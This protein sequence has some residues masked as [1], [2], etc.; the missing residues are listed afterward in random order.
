MA[1]MSIGEVARRSG[2]R[3]SAIRYYEKLG[4]LPPPSRVSG[5]R[6]YDANVLDRLA[7]VSFAKYV[8]FSIGEIRQLLNGFADRPPPERWR[9]MATRK[10]AE[11]DRV[12]AHARG[13]RSELAETL[14][15]KCPKLVECGRARR[16]GETRAGLSGLR[17]RQPLR[18]DH[19][20]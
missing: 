14:K 9:N 13:V 5:Q 12:I 8:G 2:M 19:R 10:L 3:S 6:R 18:R 1:R 7:I 4:L 20:A 15:R 16:A 11:I 17:K